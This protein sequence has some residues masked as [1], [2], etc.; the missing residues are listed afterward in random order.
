[1]RFDRKAYMKI[2]NAK[3]R[4]HLNQWSRDR[5]KEAPEQYNSYGINYRKRLRDGVLLSMGGKCSCCRN[6]DYDILNLD[7]VNN[8]GNKDRLVEGHAK[9]S[10]VYREARNMI[11][12]GENV[13]LKYS[14]MCCCCNWI[15][16]IKGSC[17]QHEHGTLG[18]IIPTRG[19]SVK[20]WNEE[21]LRLKSLNKKKL[22]LYNCDKLLSYRWLG[23]KCEKC[24]E[25]NFDMLCLDHVKN[26]GAKMR[27]ELGTVPVL[28][29]CQ[30]ILMGQRVENIFSLLCRNCNYK[31][32]VE[33]KKTRPASF[34]AGRE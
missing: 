12:S 26:N 34:D 13:F 28:T 29:V 2:W 3:N 15:K 16:N 4:E 17:G 25:R 1:M 27:R 19:Q 31:K 10:H 9:N 30:M 20:E 21:I 18:N 5:R 22:G 8:D 23:G 33:Y 14:I 7:H 24:G 32:H 6:S 11:S